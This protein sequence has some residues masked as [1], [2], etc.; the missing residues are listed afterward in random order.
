[1]SNLSKG[2]TK[3]DIPDHKSQKYLQHAIAKW[4]KQYLQF[5][6]VFYIIIDSAA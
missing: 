3:K 1:M 5:T 2:Y 6:M 4:P